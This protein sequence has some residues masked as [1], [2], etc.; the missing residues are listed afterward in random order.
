MDSV[1]TLLLN[2]VGEEKKTK[3][4]PKVRS[5]QIFVYD[6]HFQNSNFQGVL[7]KAQ[8]QHDFDT[9]DKPLITFAAKSRPPVK[10]NGIGK[11]FPMVMR[12]KASL[13]G[14]KKLSELNSLSS[15]SNAL[16]DSQSD[17]KESV[18]DESVLFLHNSKPSKSACCKKSEWAVSDLNKKSSNISQ[19]GVIS[20]L[21][22][23]NL[24]IPVISKEN[25][26]LRDEAVFSSFS[27]SSL[28]IHRF[29]VR[30]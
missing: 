10:T 22:S 30:L 13:A 6:E 24:D 28:N 2:V 23:K 1:K 29:L 12:K 3:K 5:S 27:F 25:V 20:S 7:S 18:Q 26:E 17:K 11:P 14:K 8:L 21:F 16:A 19:T 15:A 4:Q 9:V